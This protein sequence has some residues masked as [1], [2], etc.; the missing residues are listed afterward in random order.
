VLHIISRAPLE[1]AILERIASGDRVIFIE[2]AVFTLLQ[3]G[4]MQKLLAQLT[5]NT[6]CY[7]L[8]P[9]LEV[10]GIGLQTIIPGIEVIDYAGFVQLTVE[11][12]VIQSWC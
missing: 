11:H 7:A 1:T 12:P 8:V 6:H 9:D 4:Q 3:Q 2:N 10:R 5:S